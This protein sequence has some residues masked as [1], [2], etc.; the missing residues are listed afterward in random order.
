MSSLSVSA[1]EEIDR[2]LRNEGYSSIQ[3]AQE[4]Q[5]LIGRV[6]AERR[7]DFRWDVVRHLV[8]FHETPLLGRTERAAMEDCQITPAEID[9]MLNS[10]WGVNFRVGIDHVLENGLSVEDMVDRICGP[11]MGGIVYLSAITVFTEVFNS[12]YL[13]YNPD[14]E[15]TV[16]VLG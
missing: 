7:I 10:E 11:M 6:P 15:E 14:G 9:N 12:S 8:L 4:I 13:P 16:S 5:A 2:I 1:R 3:R